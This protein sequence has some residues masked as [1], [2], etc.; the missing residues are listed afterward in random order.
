MLLA[1]G[2]DFAR[3]LEHF[4]DRDRD[5]I[6][7]DLIRVM[8]DFDWQ[9]GQALQL[10]QFVDLGLADDGPETEQLALRIVV[11]AAREF[12]LVFRGYGPIWTE[13][14]NLTR[15]AGRT[16]SERAGRMRRG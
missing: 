5:V 10:L 2:V 4:R 9:V 11:E 14:P 3:R 12:A 15:E 16:H 1:E 8:D 6:E 7:P 13:I